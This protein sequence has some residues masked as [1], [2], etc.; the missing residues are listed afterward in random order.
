MVKF[1]GKTKEG[2]W[3]EGYYVFCRNHSYI[4]PI[5]NEDD[6]NSCFDERWI[7]KGADDQ[8]WFEVIPSTITQFTGKLDKNKKEIYSSIPIDGK[9]SE[10]GD[11]VK[12]SCGC[13][14]YAIEYQKD[15]AAF[16]P[17]SDGQSQVHNK[18][19]N[20]WDCELE[21]IGNQTDD[22]NLLE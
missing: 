14:I 6:L 1:K 3:V 10:G 12:L 2:K 18:D 4:L 13:C 16:V 8:G 5:H 20:V 11:I 15:K 21:V 7:Q 19:I 9:M 22:K 17:V